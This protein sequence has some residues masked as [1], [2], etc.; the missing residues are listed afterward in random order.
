MSG[1]F[2]NANPDAS[3][4]LGHANPVEFLRI[5][6]LA[7]ATDCPTNSKEHFLANASQ[8]SVVQSRSKV[9]ELIGNDT[10]SLVIR[11]QRGDRNSFATL[12]RT[13]LRAAYA[14]AL[15]ILGR[16]SDAEDI[17]QDALLLAFE[18]LDSCREPE[19]FAGW[20][21]QIV[22]NQA[23]NA[24]VSRRLR[25]VPADVTSEE[26]CSELPPPDSSIHRSQLLLALSRLTSIRREVVLLHDLEGWTHAE[27]AG[28]LR[29]SELTS[30]QH[31]FLARR[32]LR[33][34]LDGKILEV[35]HA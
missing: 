5:A 2:V 3:P 31:L 34:Q 27:I 28:A 20:L 32:E 17:A 26:P 22:R 24:L 12:T 23:R 9:V 8:P 14:V 33:K 13:Y 21:L 25:D 19:R 4:A 18:R 11:A 10:A 35:E 7:V 29:I 6:T 30:R 15:S 1:G 16:P